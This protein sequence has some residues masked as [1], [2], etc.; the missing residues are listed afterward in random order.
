[1]S[2]ELL[3]K[4]FIFGFAIPLIVLLLLL[5]FA[6]VYAE[7]GTIRRLAERRLAKKL[8]KVRGTGQVEQPSEGL[9]TS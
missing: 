7:K 8:A 5:A 2:R 3:A 4:V 6:E 9:R 1:M